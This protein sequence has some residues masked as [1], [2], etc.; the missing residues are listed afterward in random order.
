M[1]EKENEEKV[2]STLKE[3]LKRDRLK[4]TVINITPLGL[5]EITRKE[6]K[7]A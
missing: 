5:V 7:I 3:E 1:A 2:L 4:S 6:C